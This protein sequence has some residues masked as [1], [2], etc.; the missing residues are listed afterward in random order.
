MVEL[1]ACG[2]GFSGPEVLGYAGDA[3]GG[4]EG[5]PLLLKV[6]TSPSN[7]SLQAGAGVLK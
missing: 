2:E 5:V 3:A 4:V 1:G 6:S 7:L